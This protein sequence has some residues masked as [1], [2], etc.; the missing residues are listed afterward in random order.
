M[1]LLEEVKARL[2]V[3]WEYDDPKINTMIL[4]GQDFIKSRVGKTNFDTEISARKLLKEYCFYAWNGAIYS[5]ENDFKSDILNLQIK[6]SLG[7]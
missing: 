1:T 6:H 3:T 7:D 5:F 4:E 2:D